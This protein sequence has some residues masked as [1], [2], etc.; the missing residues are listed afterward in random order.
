VHTI[1]N[2]VRLIVPVLTITLLVIVDFLPFSISQ[3]AVIF[4]SLT[5]IAIFYW[6]IYRPDLVPP[7]FIFLIGLLKDIGTGTPIGLMASVFL[8][9]YGVSFSQRRFFIGKTFYFT[10]LGFA[11]I[12]AA[13]FF[14]IWTMSALFLG[15]A[16]V[17]M[18]PLM[19]YVLTVVIFPVVIWFFVR[20]QRHLVG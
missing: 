2:T 8:I 4:P 18:P 15:R 12:S 3:E 10:W 1:Y 9:I 7:I 19:Q 16:G 14:I 13:S 20:L 5:I 17:L 11:V 6:A